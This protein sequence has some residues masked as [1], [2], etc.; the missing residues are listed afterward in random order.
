MYELMKVSTDDLDLVQTHKLP[1][2][3]IFV[4][5]KAQQQIYTDLHV[6][7]SNTNRKC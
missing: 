7:I 5:S 1:E 4:N 3:S 2:L 6:T